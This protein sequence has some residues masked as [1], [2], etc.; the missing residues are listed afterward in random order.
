MLIEETHILKI[1]KQKNYQTPTE[2]VD[3]MCRTPH[4]SHIQATFS[5]HIQ[6]VIAV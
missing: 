2:E 1:R 6:R 3:A 5:S 4:S